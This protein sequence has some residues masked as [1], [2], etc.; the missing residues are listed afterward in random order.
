MRLFGRFSNTVPKVQNGLLHKPNLILHNNHVNPY[1]N[2]NFRSGISSPQRHHG[3]YV[4][5]RQMWD[6]FARSF[7]SGKTGLEKGKITEI[8]TENSKKELV[9]PGTTTSSRIPST[10]EAKNVSSQCLKITQTVSLEF[11]IF[12]H[13]SPIFV[14]FGN[15]V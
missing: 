7:M 3:E 11:F 14:L 8:S 5:P 12:W 15:T 9:T 4:I 13:F 6:I 1:Q 2:P 10:N